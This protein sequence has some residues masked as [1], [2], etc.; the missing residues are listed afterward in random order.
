MQMQPSYESLQKK[1]EENFATFPGDFN[2]RM[3]R[4]LSWLERAEKEMSA[5]DPDAAFVFYWIAF[6]ATYVGGIRRAASERDAFSDYFK[7]IIEL[8]SSMAI[9]NLIWEEF[10]DPIR[11]LLDNRY[12]FEPFWRHYSGDPDFKNWETSF[13]NS[14]Q[15]VYKFLAEQNTMGILSTLFDRLYVLRNQLLHGA[16]T[17]KG[18][19]NRDQV[20][21]GAK[22]LSYFVPQFIAVMMNHPQND[23]G[24][25]YY[26]VVSP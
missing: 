6:N 22:I 21:D 24:P 2:L 25:S 20:R 10:S 26:P 3:R 1:W 16:A 12:I 11:N 19:L 8:D 4:S 15:H 13:G 17:W 5:S 14:R 7:K 18:S 23:W 9:Y